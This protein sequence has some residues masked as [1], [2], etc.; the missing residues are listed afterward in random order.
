MKLRG[1]KL[2]EFRLIQ[3]NT[4][5]ITYENDRRNKTSII[6]DF[7]SESPTHFGAT[8]AISK[9]EQKFQIRI[10][11]ELDQTFGIP[12]FSVIY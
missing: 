9:S 8:H 5:N 1:L 6:S 11:R 12:G 3:I 10:P 2:R 4:P 7:G